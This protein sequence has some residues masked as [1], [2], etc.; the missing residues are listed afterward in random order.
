MYKRILVPTDGSPESRR[1]ANRAIALAKSMGASVSVYYAIPLVSAA[2]FADGM[3][4]PAEAIETIEAESR[5]T[6]ERYLAKVAQAAQKAGVPVDTLMSK[7]TPAEGIV[8]AARKRKC[9]AI[10]IGTHGWGAVKSLLLGSVT[11]RVL[12][13]AKI[14]VIVSR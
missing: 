10:Y 7:S 4:I 8:A 11:Q 1:A 5:K 2:L 3:P 9:D 12:H 14:P 6:G 13:L